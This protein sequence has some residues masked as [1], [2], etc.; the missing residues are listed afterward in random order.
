MMTFKKFKKK[1]RR[2]LKMGYDIY[3]NGDE[4]IDGSKFSWQLDDLE[5]VA[6]S[7]AAD[8]TLQI[9][10]ACSDEY[11]SLLLN[12]SSRLPLF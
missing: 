3:I 6:V 7:T 4:L 2:A 5:V 9:L 12:H 8:G 10:L 11:R 1:N